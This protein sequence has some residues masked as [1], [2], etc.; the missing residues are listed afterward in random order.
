[1]SPAK[2]RQHLAA[3]QH[4]VLQ[5]PAAVLLVAVK[6]INKTGARLKKTMFLPCA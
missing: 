6:V 3:L 5:K 4:P 2:H 1:M